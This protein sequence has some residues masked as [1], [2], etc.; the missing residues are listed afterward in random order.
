M[1]V[2]DGQMDSCERAGGPGG[3][4][5]EESLPP[6]HQGAGWERRRREGSLESAVV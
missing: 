5:A 4:G 2:E 3:W 6:A 1:L